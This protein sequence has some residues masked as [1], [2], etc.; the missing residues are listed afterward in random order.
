MTEV[1]L[2]QG[3]VALIDDED[4]PEV[5]KYKWHVK[6]IGRNI[7]AARNSPYDKDGKRSIIYLHVQLIGTEKK[8]NQVVDFSD[9][10]GLNY[11]RSNL[12]IAT[13]S[14]DRANSKVYAHKLSGLP[15]G[16]VLN[17]GRFRAKITID[18]KH[19]YLGTRS[20]P[21]AAHELYKTA[22]V[23]YFGEFARFE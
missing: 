6:I 7:Y 14:Q 13:K 23:K 21:E 2:T 11:Q 17:D 12:R 15:K 10:N 19:I 16:I 20:T 5:F 3:Y 1:P 9:G 8:S 4:A 22:A 18:G